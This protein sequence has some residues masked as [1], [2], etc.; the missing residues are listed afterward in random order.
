MG[1][2]KYLEMSWSTNLTFPVMA[3]VINSCREPQLQRCTPTRVRRVK[4]LFTAARSCN[5]EAQSQTGGTQ[6]LKR[7]YSS[8]S[9]IV[10]TTLRKTIRSTDGGGSNHC[11]KDRGGESAASTAY[12]TIC[13]LMANTKQA[14]Q[15]RRIRSDGSEN[16]TST[17]AGLLAL[18]NMVKAHAQGR[19]SLRKILITGLRHFSFL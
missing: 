11:P 3:C 4:Q 5:A 16:L 6:E 17:A 12:P 1:G 7:A 18:E 9:Q 10:L 19:L 14:V 13:P 15:K 8:T 2:I